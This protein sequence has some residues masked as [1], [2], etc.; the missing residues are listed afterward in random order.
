MMK[1][2]LIV[3]LLA[4]TF[5]TGV[6][7]AGT[8]FAGTSFAENGADESAAAQNVLLEGGFENASAI[9][10]NQYPAE[11]HWSVEMNTAT[12]SLSEN[13]KYEGD[14]SLKVEQQDGVILQ[15]IYFPNGITTIPADATLKTGTKYTMKMYA[16]SETACTMYMVLRHQIN[17]NG[18]SAWDL[19]N[20]TTF[21][22]DLSA[23]GDWTEITSTFIYTLEEN[24]FR[25][26]WNKEQT[27]E[28][29]TV[30][31][32]VTGLYGF[33]FGFTANVPTVYYV[34][35][36]S[37]TY[38]PEGGSA[39]E[40]EPEED[41]SVYIVNE[42]FEGD[43][44]ISAE[45]ESKEGNFYS[46]SENIPLAIEE[47][48]GL[49]GSKAI[50]VIYGG[51]E[52]TGDFSTAVMNGFRYVAYDS[53]TTKGNITVGNAYKFMYSWKSFTSGK[54]ASV[55]LD[56]I[57]HLDGVQARSITVSE[58]GS[59][60]WIRDNEWRGVSVAFA[61]IDNNG[62][63][64]ILLAGN[65]YQL[66]VNI[67]KVLRLEFS[68][69]ANSVNNSNDDCESRKFAFD[70][71]RVK[72]SKL[73]TVDIGIIPSNI[74][75]QGD[76][77]NANS[78]YDTD[79]TTRGCWDKIS[80]GGNTSVQQ[81]DEYSNTGANSL[82]MS[83][84]EKGAYVGSRLMEPSKWGTADFSAEDFDPFVPGVKHYFEAYASS[85]STATL[86]FNLRIQLSYLNEENAIRW[87]PEYFTL[88]YHTF[89][90]ENYDKFVRLGG[91]MIF[92]WDNESKTIKFWFNKEKTEDP[93]EIYT[94][95]NG[96]Y[97]YSIGF[98][99][100]EKAVFYA[101]TVSCYREFDGKVLYDGTLTSEDEIVVKN[102]FGE[103]IEQ[104][105][106]IN[107]NAIGFKNLTAPV[108]VSIANKPGCSAA[109]LNY[110]NQE[111]LIQSLY[112]VNVKYTYNG[113]TVTEGIELTASKNGS[114]IGTVTKNAD[115]TFTIDGLFG[116][117][118]L[119]LPVSDVYV[120]ATSYIVKGTYEYV[121][122][123][124]K[125]KLA[126]FSVI[127]TVRDEDGKA[128]TGAAITVNRNNEQVGSVREG[129][130]G[131]YIIEGLNDDVQGDLVVTITKQGFTF[132]DFV[133]DRNTASKKV[134]GKAVSD[135]SN[136]DTDTSGDSDSGCFSFAGTGL[137][138][139]VAGLAVAAFALKKKRE[140]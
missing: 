34:D 113:E 7:F 39:E 132:E 17:Y 41:E 47:G 116:S 96:L 43:N 30:Y 106:E 68:F 112:S 48:A 57:I 35:N 8:S 59:V 66:G 6:A 114:P 128:I 130:N 44:P 11:G 110:F 20:N 67:G 80:F 88:A 18:G 109:E 33:S 91:Y 24:V 32:N 135:S 134:T 72:P 93:S 77:E 9:H 82:K 31:E 140:D 95:V 22:V 28:P 50:T 78:I 52:V 27:E 36:C 129:S 56:A 51:K 103:V 133:V 26:W 45:S 118:I 127:I 71:V 92:D 136:S 16:K 104:E 70:N 102:V 87:A 126:D 125:A 107:G 69:T 121:I 61:L 124:E 1:R 131:S 138:L 25:L 111:A 10:S 64:E 73:T 3:L 19:W 15:R 101:D 123:V 53:K 84:D 76:F 21:G 12:V 60:G 137:S 105:Y 29:S 108:Y 119:L 75:A 62:E 4:L 74:A 81:S 99:A 89:T 23:G 49:N 79:H 86:Y 97:F 42:K 38:L 58:I 54:D 120:F 117:D 115:G 83:F 2:K 94:N 5:L 100:Y 90:G 122:P 139:A 40:P 63:A 55:G 13:E 65:K 14:T 85:K 98:T 37:I 46:L